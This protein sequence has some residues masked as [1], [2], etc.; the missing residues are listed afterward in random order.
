MSH[1]GITSGCQSCHGSTQSG[2]LFAGVMSQNPGHVNTSAAGTGAL[3]KPD[4]STCHPSTDIGGFAQFKS[5]I[6]FI[7]NPHG[8][9]GLPFSFN[10][11]TSCKACHNGTA[12]PGKVTGH[13]PVNGNAECSD[14]HGDG[15][16]A[17]SS[18]FYKVVL[19]SGEH[20]FVSS[21]TCET[22][23]ANGKTFPGL[24]PQITTPASV[25]H[26]PLNSGAPCTPCHSAA[27]KAVGGFAI[28]QVMTHTY[29]NTSSCNACHTK[30][31]NTSF[32]SITIKTTSAQAYFGGAVHIP[33]TG[34]CGVC[35]STSNFTSFDGSAI[36]GNAGHGVVNTGSC[37]GCHAKGVADYVFAPGVPVVGSQNTTI[38]PS[39][40]HNGSVANKPT[41]DC[42]SCHGSLTTFAGGGA[43][44]HS[45]SDA[46]QCKLCHVSG[47]SGKAMIANHIPTSASCD[48]CHTTWNTAAS[49]S[50]E[51]G[52]FAACSTNPKSCMGV[53]G[54]NQVSATCSD[55]HLISGNK[56]LT[57]GTAS[58]T[59]VGLA[60]GHIPLATG[61]ACDTCH[62]KVYTSFARTDWKT[63]MNHS[64]S[65]ITPVRCDVCHS[66]GAD[67]TYP[68]GVKVLGALTTPPPP[69]T[70]AYHTLSGNAP[71]ADCS[72]CHGYTTTFGG[73]VGHT[74][75][76]GDAGKCNTCHTGTGG[77]MTKITNHIAT[78]AASCDVC[79]TT[80]G[81]ALP[82]V[83]GKFAACSS[84]A[85]GCM[86]ATGH[87]AV[88][89][90]CNSCHLASGV[91]SITGGSQPV[92][93]RG[94]GSV[95][96]I[97]VVA[98]A[99]CETCH[100]SAY[101]SFLPKTGNWT[102]SMVHTS[103][104]IP[105]TPCS[106]CHGSGQSNAFPGATIKAIDSAGVTHI[107][108]TGDCV[109]CHTTGLYGTNAF[110]QS[111]N[112]S[113]M[114]HNAVSTGTCNGCH[115]ASA[116]YKTFTNTTS[117]N[118]VG[119]LV[120][121]YAG[122]GVTFPWHTGSGGTPTTDCY[123]CHTSFTT[124][125]GATNH[126]HTSA[127]NSICL[128]CHNGTGGG[129]KTKTAGHVGTTTNCYT[130]HTNYLSNLTFVGQNVGW[131]MGPAGH[132]ALTTPT[133]CNSCHTGQSFPTGVT[134]VAKGTAPPHITVLAALQCT[135]CH[136]T[137]NNTTTFANVPTFTAAM[138]SSNGNASA[139]C[140]ACHNNVAGVAKVFQGVLP[141][142]LPSGHITTSQTCETC[143]TN[144]TTFAGQN[145]GWVMSHTGNSLPCSSCHNGQAFTSTTG[146]KYDRNP[147]NTTN[148]MT[149]GLTHVPLT[150]GI[151]TECTSCHS[152]TTA[153]STEAMSHGSFTSSKTTV[154]AAGCA[155]CHSDNLA[156]NIQTGA[157]ML[158]SPKKGKVTLGSHEGSKTTQD[159]VAC[160]TMVFTRWNSP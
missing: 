127:D 156:S 12:A 71:T 60:A 53:A 106:A 122:A 48:A 13:I 135:A 124:F 80:W 103:A 20:D 90:T 105:L 99:V 104:V 23:H 33:V 50:N 22:C 39:N 21:S 77:G 42:S 120:P 131:V 87:A 144:T 41:L 130:C 75:V 37:S 101:S 159:C 145:A 43:H 146:G 155:K 51:T 126:V 91:K 72:D 16:S 18:S 67:K 46:S 74:H 1:T 153:F 107:P 97:P 14:C 40:Y 8:N 7:G 118:I 113:N 150:S 142:P 34:D 62:G 147:R 55:C 92:N 137:S 52:V 17:L 36:M 129:G 117:V 45:A 115:L 26:I 59:V 93:I 111:W 79:H 61:A 94:V 116:A 152:S 10:G 49:L 65:V 123:G 47:G 73:A 57:G 58:V 96:H 28:G 82:S 6:G 15:S 56:S 134:P 30:P 148:G 32:K 133:A 63:A 3:N 78:T 125:G 109:A 31:A 66:A 84:N 68:T 4:C 38:Y 85:N 98:T 151:P 141:K 25:N 44:K 76:A 128:N 132:A 160:H 81:S 149:G 70:S 69:G 100:A 110:S 108:V 140:S 2:D 139:G 19:S 102:S 143:H 88:T 121:S 112:A 119:A 138:H 95:N 11:V 29:V 83:T 136:N 154:P 35:H 89:G 64:A 157:K 54:H 9:V 5:G 27:N 24:S 158:A 114:N 86:G